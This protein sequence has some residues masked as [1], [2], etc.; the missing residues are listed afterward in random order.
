MLF[1]DWQEHNSDESR[2]EELLFN[3][4]RGLRGKEGEE[5]LPESCGMNE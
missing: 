2:E 1:P 5:L 4:K 3:W